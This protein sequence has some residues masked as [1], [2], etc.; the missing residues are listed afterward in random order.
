M[1]SLSSESRGNG[2][3]NWQAIRSFDDVKRNY[4]RMLGGFT[5][6]YENRWRDCRVQNLWDLTLCILDI[7]AQQQVELHAFVV[8]GG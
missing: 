2:S 8:V 3:A 4:I 1:N 5:A 6:V 7:D